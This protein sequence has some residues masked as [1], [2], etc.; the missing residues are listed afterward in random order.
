MLADLADAEDY[1]NSSDDEEPPELADESAE[2]HDD[3]GG[4][5]KGDAQADEQVGED[6]ND[7]L[8]Q[9]A[10]DERRDGDHR[11][12]VDQRRLDGGAQADGLFDVRGQALQDDVQ[13]TAGF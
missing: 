12:R 9:G 4:Q 13:N 8:E 5:G 10:D 7:P 1:A 11:D 3:P 6:G 2:A